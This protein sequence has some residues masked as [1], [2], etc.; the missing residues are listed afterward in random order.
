MR[1]EIQSDYSSHLYSESKLNP[2]KIPVNPPT[3]EE[4]DKKVDGRIIL[5]DNFR[6]ILRKYD[7]VLIFG[8]D[9]G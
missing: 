7:N 5:R 1:H 9:A 2:T 4:E 6:E 3:Y 8:E